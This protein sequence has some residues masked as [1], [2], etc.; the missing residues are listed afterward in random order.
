M[1]SLPVLL[2]GLCGG[3][4]LVRPGNLLQWCGTIHEWQL[5]QERIAIHS[6]GY[7]RVC[8]VGQVFFVLELAKQP[9]LRAL[10]GVCG[11]GYLRVIGRGIK[12][13]TAYS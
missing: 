10:F 9:L 7:H 8:L 5:W 6:L 4:F 1:V 12:L 11:R 2:P 3:W 13:A